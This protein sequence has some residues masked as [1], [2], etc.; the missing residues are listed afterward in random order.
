MDINDLTRRI[1][2]DTPEYDPVIALHNRRVDIYR[3]EKALR[4]LDESLETFDPESIYEVGWGRS[5]YEEWTRFQTRQTS[6]CYYAAGQ[7]GVERQFQRA[8][9]EVRKNRNKPDTSFH[10]GRCAYEDL[11]AY[12]AWC[13]T[14]L[15]SEQGRLIRFEERIAAGEFSI[16]RSRKEPLSGEVN[17][18]K[19]GF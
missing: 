7:D 15:E 17:W 5:G 9:V 2:H 18:M 3:A 4:R 16:A 11:L 10:L 12:R 19:E 14:S 6:R 1:P 8:T 13:T